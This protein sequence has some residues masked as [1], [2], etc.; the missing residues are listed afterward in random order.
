MSIPLATAIPVSVAEIVEVVAPATLQEGF[1]FQAIYNKTPFTV[2]VPAG[3]VKEGQKIRVPFMPTP[4][5]SE[6]APL[7]GDAAPQGKWKDDLCDC[8]KHGFCHPS[9]LNACC[10]PQILMAQVLTRLKMNMFGKPSPEAWRFTFK[11][12]FILVFSY[13]I[14]A[15][16]LRPPPPTFELDDEGT[17]IAVPP[18]V[19]PWQGIAYYIISTAFGIYTLL[20][21]MRTR[22][23]VRARF[24]IPEQQC[25]GMEDCCC[26]LW[27]GCCTVAQLAR[28]TGD[29][30]NTSAI[31]CTETGLPPTHEAVVV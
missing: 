6:F 28:Q 29:Y 5:V 11:R 18:D 22:A 12:I 20:V 1:S 23:A 24:Q 7:V 4:V 30:E 16:F 17:T 14:L 10:V 9:L 3:G 8:T 13:W 21:L 15:S 2:T 27:C 25:H 26:A 31:C 19:P